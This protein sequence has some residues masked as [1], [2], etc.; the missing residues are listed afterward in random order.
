MV[1][2]TLGWLGGHVL[3]AGR[4]GLEQDLAA[5]RK[6]QLDQVFQH[7]VLGVDRDHTAIGEVV[8]VDAV[9]AAGEAQLEAMVDEALPL[10]ALAGA[11]LRHQVDGGL[12]QHPGA[13][14]GLDRLAG[15]AL[16]DDRL[17]AAKMQHLREQQSRRARSN[18][19]NLC[20]HPASPHLSS[21]AR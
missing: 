14:R 20:A 11:D 9:A 10:H 17:D 18:N 4:L 5:G 1:K 12:L 7:L 6:P 3:Q 8:Q 13:D 15:A 2:R 21:G 19:A 16:D